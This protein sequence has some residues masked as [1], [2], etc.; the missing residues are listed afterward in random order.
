MKII[1]LHGLESTPETSSSAKLIK[2]NFE[3][4]QVPDYNPKD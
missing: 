2:D 1:F 3:N 4:V